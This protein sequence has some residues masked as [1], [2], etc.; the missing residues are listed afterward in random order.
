MT[1]SLRIESAEQMRALGA[2]LSSAVASIGASVCV[3]AL[4]GELGVGKTTLVRGF[5]QA[6]GIEGPVRSPTYTLIEPYE[7]NGRR[8]FHLDLYRLTQ[9]SEVEQLG[10]RDLLEDG[11]VLLIEWPQRGVGHIPAADLAVR[12]QYGS[13]EGTRSVSLQANS[14]V[15]FDVAQACSD[16]PEI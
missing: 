16:A 13:A 5:I 4:E 3:I 12:I 2:Q 9:P 14:A 1:T 15:G 10:L 7:L 8:I 11:A 6:L